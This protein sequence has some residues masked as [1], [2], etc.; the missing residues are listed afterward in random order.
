MKTVKTKDFSNFVKKLEKKQTI[1]AKANLEKLVRK[2][3][4]IF[5]I[6]VVIFSK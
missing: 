5:I 4:E 1:N 6:Q 2:K 3:Y